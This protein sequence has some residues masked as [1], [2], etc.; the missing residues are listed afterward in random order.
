MDPLRAYAELGRIKL[1]KTSI[2]GVFSR[3]TDLAHQGLRGADESSITLLRES[4]Q[5]AAASSELAR[6]LDEAQYEHAAGPCLQ[7]ATQDAVVSVVDTA[8]DLRWPEWAGVASAAGI[9]SALSVSLPVREAVR[10][11]LNMYSRAR[12]AFDEATV[13]TAQTFAGHAAV[14]LANALLYDATLTL[15]DQLRRA[16][17][18]RAV[19]EQAKGVVMSERRCTADE[20]FAILTRM[21]QTSNRKLRDVASALVTRAGKDPGG[22]TAV[23]GAD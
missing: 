6:L 1:D 10:G 3:I 8:A 13:A 21:S 7:A 19:I 5:T 16:M 20:A 2:D 18:H 14:V 15:N 9:G 12:D 17:E 22:R 4:P 23:A 11:S